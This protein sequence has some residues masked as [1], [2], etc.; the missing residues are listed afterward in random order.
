MITYFNLEF[1]YLEKLPWWGQ[2]VEE[3]IYFFSAF[4]EL[5][6]KLWHAFICVCQDAHNYQSRYNLRPLF[7][8]SWVLPDYYSI[9]WSL[10]RVWLFY[11][12]IHSFTC[13]FIHPFIHSQT[14]QFLSCTH[15]PSLQGVRASYRVSL[16]YWHLKPDHCLFGGWGLSCAL[17]HV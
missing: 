4:I 14:F 6:D 13:L 7:H 12:L 8:V 1:Y 15:S 9:I 11:T 16:R 10:V 17:Q 3:G 5:T 2:R